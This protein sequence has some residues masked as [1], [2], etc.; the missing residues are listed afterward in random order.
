MVTH[1][2][3]ERRV[4]DYVKIYNYTFDQPA[5]LNAI[6]FMYS[7]WSD[8]SNLTLVRQ[9]IIDVSGVIWMIF[10]NQ[11]YYLPPVDDHRLVVHRRQ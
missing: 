9:G 8:P 6:S 3:F 11:N 2:D 10:L 7:P 5:L 1:A 4:K